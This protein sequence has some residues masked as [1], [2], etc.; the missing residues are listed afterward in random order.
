MSNNNVGFNTSNIYNKISKISN[1]N[2]LSETS[3]KKSTKIIINS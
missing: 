3:F 1:I 2:K